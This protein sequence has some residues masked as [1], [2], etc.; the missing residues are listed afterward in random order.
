[1]HTAWERAPDE[2]RAIVRA[3][4]AFTNLL[5]P[6]TEPILDVATRFLW[7]EEMQ[8]STDAFTRNHVA[9]FAGA[10]GSGGEQRLEWTEAHK[11]FCDLFEFQ[12]EQFVESQDFTQQEFVDACQDALTNGADSWAVRIQHCNDVPRSLYGLAV[13]GRGR[14][15]QLSV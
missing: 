13:P 7:S 5:N 10:E 9:L 1:M 8:E 15:T 12:L 2:P 6:K 4:M 3:E 11:E 14:Q